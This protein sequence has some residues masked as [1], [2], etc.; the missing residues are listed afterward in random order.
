MDNRIKKV[1][2]VSVSS[3]F[4]VFC[5]TACGSNSGT[6]SSDGVDDTQSESIFQNIVNLEYVNYDGI[7]E[8]AQWVKSL[9]EYN[10][11]GLNKEYNDDFFKNRI[12]FVLKMDWSSTGPN[13]TLVEN[14]VLE[15]G[16]LFPVIN[17]H[18]DSGT[19]SPAFTT[20]VMIAEVE[21][22]YASMSLGE[23]KFTYSGKGYDYMNQ[24][25]FHYVEYKNPEELQKLEY[26]IHWIKTYKE[27]CDLEWEGSL[28]EEYFEKYAL[29]FIK[30]KWTSSTPSITL[31]REPIVEGDVYHPVLNVHIKKD[32]VDDIMQTSVICV[33][34]EKKYE[35]VIIGE[36]RFS[37]SGSFYEKEENKQYN[38]YYPTINNE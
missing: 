6:E 29:L 38:F 2:L 28:T 13:R 17:I 11:L 12:L 36:L 37:Y 10:A 32:S 26:G 35:N 15:E 31:I 25:I 22:K 5:I 19:S 8:G 20:T 30:T 24:L 23:I 1:F 33:R 3:I 21:K 34:V 27:Y 9:D 14:P 7:F 18:S 16:T 4:L